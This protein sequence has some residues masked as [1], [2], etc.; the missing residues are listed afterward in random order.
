MSRITRK[1]L[2]LLVSRINE[3]TNSPLTYSDKR[4][5]PHIGHYHL[6]GAYG[7]LKLVRTMS[8]S[9]EIKDITKTGYTTKRELYNEMSAFLRGIEYAKELLS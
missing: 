1:D 8:E 9:G 5:K 7:G 4:F 3:A 2:E 6:S